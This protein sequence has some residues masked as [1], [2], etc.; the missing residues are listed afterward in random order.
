MKIKIKAQK[1][2]IQIP[3]LIAI[4]VSIIA[5]TGIGYGI[6]EYRKTV[7]II[8]EAKQLTKV[9]KYNEAIAKLEVGLNGWTIKNL[10]IKRQE[11][12]N[13][14]EK[15]KQLL[16]DETEYNQGIED[17][18]KKDWESAEELLSKV[19][20][21]SSYYQDAKSK[22]KESQ[23]M[24]TGKRIAE[25]IGKA[26]EETKQE[27]EKITKE[28]E[29]AKKEAEEAKKIA[30]DAQGKIKEEPKAD[31]VSL[32]EQWRPI[33]AYIECDFYY[34]GTDIKY[35]TVA[36][37]GVLNK[38]DHKGHPILITNRHVVVDQEKY[39][40]KIC[41]IK[42]PDRK[43]V[44]SVP[45]E[46]IFESSKGYDVAKIWIGYYPYSGDY[47]SFDVC[48]ETPS[49]GEEVI[50]LG[51]PAIGSSNDITATEGIISG[52]DGN[53]YITSAKIE[54]GNSGGAAILTNK[55]CYLGIPTFAQVGSIE[56]LSRILKP[57]PFW[58]QR[59]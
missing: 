6:F 25:A 21:D 22:I 8:E 52:Y 27:M 5:T 16:I 30:E 7:K 9:E 59:E 15:N 11:I 39:S 40:P 45:T 12:F 1:G 17:F 4:I 36:G 31:I 50:I 56:S 42:L 26:T 38:R 29:I 55:N 32:I 49:I 53:Y 37:S 23:E 33:I 24:I 35:L 34:E 3:I 18:N 44:I 14:I 41:R 10:G 2:F 58:W 20:E 28:T 46:N 19:S 54:H 48:T 47:Y 51:Y 13:W 43:D 57:L